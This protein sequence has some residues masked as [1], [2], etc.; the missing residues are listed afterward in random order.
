MDDDACEMGYLSDYDEETIE[1][2]NEAF[3]YWEE[4][5]FDMAEP[6]L[7]KSALAQYSYSMPKYALILMDH[8]HLA[9]S[10]QPKEDMAMGA[11][12]MLRAHLRGQELATDYLDQE[13]LSSLPEIKLLLGSRD[14]QVNRW[15]CGILVRTAQDRQRLYPPI[16]ISA[17]SR[18]VM[19]HC[20]LSSKAIEEN[21]ERRPTTTAHQ[22]GT[23]GDKTCDKTI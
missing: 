3:F 21:P 13:N 14:P 19:Y 2:A 7:A 16:V 20:S 4:R 18:F 17:I 1:A 8:E 23:P 12:L 5:Q 6:Y 11:D 10:S 22:G 15:V 9:A